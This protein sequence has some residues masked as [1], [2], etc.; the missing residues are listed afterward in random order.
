MNTR[1]NI[2]NIIRDLA[3]ENFTAYPECYPIENGK[4]T[5]ECLDALDL[6][7]E[8][9]FDNRQESEIE[10]DQNAINEPVTLEDYKNWV[11]LKFESFIE[12]C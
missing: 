1:E 8:S 4:P 6:L 12:I 11:L 2:Q 5:Q 9:Y 10:R 7:A 3:S